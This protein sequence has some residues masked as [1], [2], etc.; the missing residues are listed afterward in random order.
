M[1]ETLIA[2]LQEGNLRWQQRQ[3]EQTAMRRKTAAEG[4]QPYAIVIAC[5]DSRV[6]PEQLF[7]AGLGELFVIRVAGN[8]L[9]RHQLGSIEYAAGHLHCRLILM[10]GHTGCGAVGAALDRGGDG[11]IQYITDE[12]LLAVGEERDPV[13]ACERN[14][15]RG[16]EIL[17][18]EFREHPEIPTEKLEI[19]GA[20][21]D[22]ASGEVRWLED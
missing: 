16:V 2:R 1:K 6:I 21:Y 5:S 14:V 20:V 11:F 7:D 12:I 13:L 19:R 4:Q 15:R 17:R 10:L 18:R 8:V 3:D 9:D 22:I